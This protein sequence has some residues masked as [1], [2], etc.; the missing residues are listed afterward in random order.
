MP[1]CLPVFVGYDRREEPAHDV[2]VRSLV[3]HASIALH[4]QRLD[5]RRLELAGLY[6][7][8][9]GE[10]GPGFVDG[11][12]GTG[13]STEFSFTRFLVPALC[14]WRG[15]ALF[16]DGDLLWRG[17]VAGLLALADDARAAMVVKHDYRPPERRKMR[18]QAQ[19]PYPRKNWSSLILWNCAHPANRRL[20]P[21][22]VNARPGAW[23]HRFGWLADDEIGALPETWNWL[24]G[25]GTD[26]DPDPEV[27]HFTRGTPDMLPDKPL[28]H[29]E[30]WWGVLANRE[31]DHGDL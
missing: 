6:R 2:T 19:A 24:E 3:A 13:F 4:V 8:A 21:D 14:Q 5:I 29:A 20:T 30:E 7:R 27:V 11:F 23:L 10:R 17:D 25:H 16:C 26:P 1:E 15:W 12:D 28:P 18:G 9:Y 31:R 22:E